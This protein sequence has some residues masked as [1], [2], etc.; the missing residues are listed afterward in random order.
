M[1][2]LLQQLSLSGF[3]GE[4]IRKDLSDNNEMSIDYAHFVT[5]LA[6]EIGVLLETEER[7]KPPEGT[8]L[9]TLTSWKMEVSSFIKE[10]HCPIPFL[11]EGDLKNRLNSSV[12]RIILL[13]FLLSELLSARME[14]VEKST[15]ESPR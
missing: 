13:D 4:S 8:N 12:H 9:D 6:S 14:K 7:L 1:E 10:L 3:N 5:Q 11:Y 2:K 15:S